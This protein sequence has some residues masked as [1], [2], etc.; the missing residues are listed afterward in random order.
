MD[1]LKWSMHLFIWDAWLTP[2]GSR[3]DVLHWIGIARS[4]INMLERRIWKSCI[5]LKTKLRLYH[6]YIVPVL[7]YG[8]ETTK[9]L[10]CHLDIFDTWALCTI[11]RIPYTRHVSNTEVRGTT[12]CLPLSHLV[13]NRRL[14]LFGLIARS[15]PHEDHHW[16]LAAAVRQVPDDCKWPVGRP[17]TLGAVQLRQTLALWTSALW[18]PGE[19]PLLEMNDDIL[20]T[21]Q[22]SSG[23]R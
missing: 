5:R 23:V 3:G 8:C 22:R 15:S 13:T 18:L 14:Q 19:R 4:C 2:C 16:A 12:G 21:Q 9:Y 10:R 6:T 11:L 7:M 1:M 20:W 17:T